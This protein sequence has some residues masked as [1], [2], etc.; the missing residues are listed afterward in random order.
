[1]E[2]PAKNE[3][4]I[5]SCFMERSLGLH[6]LGAT[7]QDLAPWVV[8][9]IRRH[10]KLIYSMFDGTFFCFKIPLATKC[11]RAIPFLCCGGWW[12]WW[13][14]YFLMLNQS[15]YPKLE[16]PKIDSQRPNS[17]SQIPKLDS[18]THEID[19][20]RPQID[21]KSLNSLYRGQT[22]TC[23]GP[24]LSDPKSTPRGPKMDSLIVKL[25]S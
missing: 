5:E 25:D 4:V 22:S 15:P 7:T 19:F 21:N 24:K 18:Q 12:W 2:N 10:F 20:Q 23:R 6:Y 11:S 16:V 14:A 8:I 13:W 1:M 9:G 17:D 3:E